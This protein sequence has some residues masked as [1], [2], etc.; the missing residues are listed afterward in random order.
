MKAKVANLLGYIG[1]TIVLAAVGAVTFLVFKA[2]F[3]DISKTTDFIIAFAGAFF[4]Y[5]FVKLGELGTRLYGRQRANQTALVGLEQ[6]Q[7]EYVNRLARNDFVADDIIATI[8][9]ATS[10]P[11]STPKVNFNF[12]KPIPINTSPL[13]DLRNIDYKNDLFNFHEDLE[14]V[15]GSMESVQRYYDLLTS[16]LISGQLDKKTYLNNLLIIKEKL[17]E[18][19]KFLAGSTDDCIDV[20]TKTRLLLKERSVW[21]ATALQ[22][23]PQNYTEAFKAKIPNERKAVEKEMKDNTAESLERIKKLLDR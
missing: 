10:E 6:S 3:G 2:S 20:A 17:L 12:L 4:A 16:S 11:E 1:V 19:K 22:L 7:Q 15:N 23:K 5:V 13:L 18:L 14:K 21:L 8:D 9:K